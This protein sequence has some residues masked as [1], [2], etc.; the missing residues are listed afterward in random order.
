MKTNYPSLKKLFLII[1]SALLCCDA[2]A[3]LLPDSNY[4]DIASVPDAVM[5]ANKTW[6]FI[7]SND[8]SA[9]NTVLQQHFVPY[10]TFPYKKLIRP[11]LVSKLFYLQ[12]GLINS[13]NFSDSVYVFPGSMFDNILVYSV[14]N[15]N[16][17]VY[18][19]DGSKS[20]YYR[21]ALAPHEKK[22][23]LI[24]LDLCRHNFNYI[25]PQIIRSNYLETYISI[26]RN[27]ITN[28]RYVGFLLSGMLF[29][30]ILFVA[31]NYILT[32]KKEFL[33][34]LGYSLFTFLLIFLYAFTAGTWGSFAS[35]HNGYFDVFLLILSTVFYLAFCRHFLN[36]KVNYKILDQVFKV[37]EWFLL[38]L[39][40]AFTFIHY[41]TEWYVVESFLENLMKV[42][43]LVMGIVFIVIAFKQKD[44]LIVYLAL[45]SAFAIFFSSISLALIL[46]NVIPK[47]IFLHAL[48]YHDIGLVFALAFFLLGLTY[49]NRRELVENIQE[50][51][52][53]KLDIE[54]KDFEKQLAIIKAQQE[55]RNRISADMHDDLGAG[56]TTIRLYSELA[57]SRIGDKNIPE[58][59]KISSSANELL[60]KM[61]AII[62]SMSSSNDSLHN[63]I[64]Y[65]RSYSLE[66]FENSGINCRITIPENLPNIVVSGEIRRNVFLVVKEALNNIL[67]HSG[68]TE[69]TITLERVTDGL[70]LFIHDNG[71]G[72]DFEK[73]RQFGNGLKN[74]KKRMDD[75]N[76]RFSI[77]NQNG[78]LITL[79]R[80]VENFNAF[81]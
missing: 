58:I 33:Y 57:K 51:E 7:D 17:L 40:F 42:F 80:V 36:T 50:Q 53:M 34:Y 47:S 55:E 77:Q 13:S 28:I 14:V 49:K 11:K 48:F 8:V 67:K 32:R 69:V 43:V 23:I 52:A 16:Q 65:I 70:K 76:V 75:I 37:E 54:K 29:L 79:H 39:L 27:S 78:T 61:N 73:L 38:L 71:R 22:L 6:V 24:K 12:I 62:W 18:E 64:A 15:G 10:K 46:L 19:G 31:V 3:Q 81:S 9:T 72:I 35:F 60:N 26:Y 21:Q 44:R 25:R 74:M 63:M 2:S 30:M 56:M 66:Y 59:E 41:F 5:V 20:G 1:C 45:G 4:V 68:A